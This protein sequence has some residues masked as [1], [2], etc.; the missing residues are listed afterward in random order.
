MNIKKITELLVRNMKIINIIGGLILIFCATFFFISIFNSRTNSKLAK[1]QY[2]VF[3]IKFGKKNYDDAVSAFEKAMQLSPSQYEPTREYGL[4][5]IHT[6]RLKEAEQVFNNLITKNPR[7]SILYA[8]RA[9]IWEIRDNYDAM[10]NDLQQSFKIDT[11]LPY[12][13]IQMGD[14]YF[15]KGEFDKAANYMDQGIKLYKKKKLDVEYPYNYGTYVNILLKYKR[16]SNAIREIENQNI[17][18]I[19]TLEEIYN[20]KEVRFIKGIRINIYFG[21]SIKRLLSEDFNKANYLRNNIK[22]KNVDGKASLVMDWYFAIND[23]NVN[24][25]R[26]ELA[27]FTK[28]KKD[29]LKSL[30]GKIEICKIDYNSYTFGEQREF[31]RN[32]PNILNTVHNKEEK[33]IITDLLFMIYFLSNWDVEIKYELRD[34]LLSKMRNNMRFAESLKRIFL[35]L[36]LSDDGRNS[37]IEFSYKLAQKSDSDKIKIIISDVY[38][39]AIKQNDY[40]LVINKKQVYNVIYYLIDL[41]KNRPKIEPWENT[42]IDWYNKREINIKDKNAIQFY[43]LKNEKRKILNYFIEQIKANNYDLEIVEKINIIESLIKSRDTLSVEDIVEELENEISK[44]G[45]IFP[46]SKESK[47][48]YNLIN[49]IIAIIGCLVSLVL[50]GLNIIKMKKNAFN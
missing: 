18:D 27:S 43:E 13:H 42:L 50:F 33:S 1:Q 24:D 10:Q 16:Y 4:S 37:V 29:S 5:L 6:R 15:K 35:D 41:A 28:E 2:E 25:N 36:M 45:G 12:S 19:S 23:P 3:N 46:I 31:L 21:N 8:N 49:L 39:S 32:I 44:L 11:E 48:P 17:T 47:I 26:N 30:I 20:N 40:G 22:Y 14:F 38:S 34:L 9:L 7:S